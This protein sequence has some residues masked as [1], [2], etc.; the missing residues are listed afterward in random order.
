MTKTRRKYSIVCS[1]YLTFSS[2]SLYF[3]ADAGIIEYNRI[4]KEEWVRYHIVFLFMIAFLTLIFASCSTYPRIDEVKSGVNP[5][6][7][8]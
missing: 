7:N 8:P 1:F 3:D 4:Q 6:F 2:F 5:S